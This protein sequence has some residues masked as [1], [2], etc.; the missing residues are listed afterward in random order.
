MSSRGSSGVIRGVIWVHPGGSKIKKNEIFRKKMQFSKKVVEKSMINGI[1]R[2]FC[3]EFDFFIGLGRNRLK[4]I[5]KSTFS[6]EKIYGKNMDENHRTST[7]RPALHGY[8]KSNICCTGAALLFQAH[9][10]RS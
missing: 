9:E 7:S 8:M 1:D 3:A 6:I 10:S 4:I 2:A 5:E